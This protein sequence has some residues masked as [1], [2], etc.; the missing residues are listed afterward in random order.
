LPVNASARRISSLAQRKREAVAW[1]RQV[2]R[3]KT[4]ID[5]QFT[6]Q[7]TRKKFGHDR[8]SFARSEN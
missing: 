2:N 4:V 6:R 1:N 3:D 5:W 8:D 7:A